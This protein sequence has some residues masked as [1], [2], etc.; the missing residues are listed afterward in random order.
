MEHEASGAGKHDDFKVTLGIGD[1]DILP[2]GNDAFRLLCILRVFRMVLNRSPYDRRVETLFQDLPAHAARR[3][4]ISHPLLW[5]DRH[6]SNRLA[7]IRGQDTACRR[8]D[9]P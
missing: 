1:M 6:F 4:A 2:A 8:A 3:V 9:R 7:P 5:I